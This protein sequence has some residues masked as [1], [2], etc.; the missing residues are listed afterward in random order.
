M[1]RLGKVIGYGSLLLAASMFVVLLWG[2]ALAMFSNG[3]SDFMTGFES[4][5]KGGYD[6]WEWFY[7][8]RHLGGI[9]TTFAIPAALGGLVLWGWVLF[10]LHIARGKSRRSAQQ[11]RVH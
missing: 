2:I 10:F 5:P 11:P 4:E 9:L 1:K 3:L 8:K 6:Y 7:I